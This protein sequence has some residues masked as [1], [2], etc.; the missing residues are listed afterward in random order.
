MVLKLIMSI[1]AHPLTYNS[2]GNFLYLTLESK[3]DFSVVLL[4]DYLPMIYSLPN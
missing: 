4:G 1:T 2:L 3:N